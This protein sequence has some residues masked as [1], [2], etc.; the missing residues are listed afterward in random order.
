MK[1]VRKARA[2]RPG[3]A[4]RSS[5]PPPPPTR[6]KES[7]RKTIRG[8]RCQTVPYFDFQKLCVLALFHFMNAGQLKMLLTVSKNGTAKIFGLPPVVKQYII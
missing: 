2:S 1:P 5:P 6:K 3:V 7:Q 4:Q 8:E